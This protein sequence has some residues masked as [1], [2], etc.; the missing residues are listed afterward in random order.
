[1]CA[2]FPV[3]SLVMVFINK[4][5]FIPVYYMCMCLSAG[6]EGA[7]FQSRLPVDKMTSQEASCFPDLVNGSTQGQKIFL[8]LRN[9]M[10]RRLPLS[11]Q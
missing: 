11:L 4:G 7:A 6:L 8:Y 5:W 1:M 9:R 2:G 3:C 10:V